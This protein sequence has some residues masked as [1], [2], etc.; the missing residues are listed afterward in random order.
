MIMEEL[1]SATASAHARTEAA[2]PSLE[3]LAEPAG[4]L[5]YLAAMHG[6]HSVWEPAVWSLLDGQLLTLEAA[7][8]QKLPALGR[9]LASLRRRWPITLL[10]PPAAPRLPSVAASL[11]ALYVMEGATLGGRVIERTVAEPLGIA[12]DDGGEYLHGYG[13]ETG[14]MWR[15]FGQCTASW[16]EQHG[17]QAAVVQGAL[18]CFGALESW[19]ATE[20]ARDGGRGLV[21][22]D[23]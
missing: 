7:R 8:R 2:L 16:V 17:Q 21:V 23:A 11:G 10:C 18:A 15:R 4:Y 12:S 20:C 6:F 9:D 1:K 3:L 13:D 14:T 19:L 22:M 5:G